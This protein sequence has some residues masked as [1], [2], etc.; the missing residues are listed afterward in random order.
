MLCKASLLCEL[1]VSGH[2]YMHKIDD[3][4]HTCIFKCVYVCCCVHLWSS[5]VTM[6]VPG[7]RVYLNISIGLFV[8]HPGLFRL[9][10]HKVQGNYS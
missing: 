5:K 6:H 8:L 4:Q 7:I 9:F 1:C 2:V 3:M 10:C